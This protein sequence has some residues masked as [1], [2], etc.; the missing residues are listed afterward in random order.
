MDVF[1]GLCLR[2]YTLE[3]KNGDKLELQRGKDY[4]ISKPEIK[5][6]KWMVVVFANFWV[7]VP[8]DLF[9][10]IEPLYGGAARESQS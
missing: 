6:G 2:D 10:G 5:D 4:T 8:A 7:P 3:A 9:G 1:K